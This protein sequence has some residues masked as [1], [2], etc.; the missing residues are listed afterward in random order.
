MYP[1]SKTSTKFLNIVEFEATH[2]NFQILSERSKASALGKPKE[3]Y[4]VT[5]FVVKSTLLT[6]QNTVV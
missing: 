3:W 4:C 5:V 2:F 1:T 6:I